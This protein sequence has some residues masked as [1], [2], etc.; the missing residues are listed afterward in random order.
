[1][2]GG[3]QLTTNNK[4]VQN[5][6]SGQT[7]ESLKVMRTTTV[8]DA[9]ALLND[10]KSAKK[11]IFNVTQAID[12]KQKS[13]AEQAKVVVKEEKVA[14][15]PK[16]EQQKPVVE[17]KKVVESVVAEKPEVKQEAPVAQE[18][19]SSVN[20]EITYVKPLID[21]QPKDQKIFIDDKGNKIVRKFITDRFPQKPAQP[22]GQSQHQHGDRH[23]QRGNFNG[24]GRPQGQGQGQR[25]PF[26]PNRPRP[27]FDKNRNFN[28]KDKDDNKQNV[29]QKPAQKPKA[30]AG[31]LPV[32]PK[33]PQGKNFGNKNKT[34][35]TNSEETQNYELP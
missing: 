33:E 11:R 2:C 34:P 26:D 12:K 5:N 14:E 27:Q 28:D 24:Q 18:K 7:F 1:M 8:K 20:I 22:Q 6:Q 21:Q 30:F 13:F 35:E 9:S 10:V 29:S 23:Q 31:D 3:S 16:V 19:K 25:K 15:Q 4:V 17:E 32:I